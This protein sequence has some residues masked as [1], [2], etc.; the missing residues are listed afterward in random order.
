M[1]FLR[2]IVRAVGHHPQ[3]SPRDHTAPPVDETFLRRRRRKASIGG[4]PA[5]VRSVEPYT[6]PPP[7]EAERLL[8]LY[9]STINLMIPCIHEGSF[10]AIWAKAC[11][12]GCRAVPRP[13]LGVICMVLALATNVM[14]PTSPSVERATLANLYFQRAMELVKPEI[15]GHPSIEL[16]QLFCLMVIYLEGTRYSSLAW[17]FHGLAVKGGY[18]L[19]L[20]FAGSKNHTPLAREVRRR[21]WYWCVINDR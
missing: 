16:V 5:R 8:R 11:S 14:T 13:W 7:A 12:E 10:R 15:L 18:Q 1:A 9:F 3:A 20:H 4:S 2:F 19:G 6:L 21:L 17:T